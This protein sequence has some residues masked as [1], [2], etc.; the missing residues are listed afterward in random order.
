MIN[1]A[2][3]ILSSSFTATDDDDDDDDEEDEEEE[4]EEEEEEVLF[5]LSSLNFLFLS[6]SNSSSSFPYHAIRLCTYLYPEINK[7]LS[8]VIF[9]SL[10]RQ[11]EMS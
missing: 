4:E 9:L 10:S 11:R 1:N 6:L 7:K 2:A 3:P 8:A 5:L